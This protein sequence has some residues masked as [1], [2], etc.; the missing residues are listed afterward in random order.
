[1]DKS[2]EL[3]I[4]KSVFVKNKSGTITDEYKIGKVRRRLLRNSAKEHMELYIV[5]H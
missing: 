2:I 5:P 4:N 3:C 1:M